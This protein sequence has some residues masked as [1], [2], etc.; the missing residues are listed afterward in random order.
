MPCS[1]TFNED[2]QRHGVSRRAFPAAVRALPRGPAV[3]PLPYG[4]DLHRHVGDRDDRQ[5]G[6]ARGRRS[7]HAAALSALCVGGLRVFFLLVRL[8]IAYALRAVDTSSEPGGG[9][10]P[11]PPVRHTPATQR[12]GTGRR[13]RPWPVRILGEF[14]GEAV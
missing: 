6:R 10:P 9:S 2:G 11:A 14:V 12:T 4:A 1:A 5:Q 8:W 3:C 13:E 7:L